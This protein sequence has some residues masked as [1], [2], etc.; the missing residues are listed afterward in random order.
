MTHQP[1]RCKVHSITTPL[2]Q[3]KKETKSQNTTGHT[4]TPCFQAF[5]FFSS[6]TGPPFFFFFF[7]FFLFFCFSFLFFH[8]L[9]SHFPPQLSL[10]HVS[11]HY[12]FGLSWG[13]K[14][15]SKQCQIQRKNDLCMIAFTA[16]QSFF[17]LYSRHGPSNSTS[18]FPIF[19][20]SQQN[21]IFLFFI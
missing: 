3:T 14:A 13:Q 19:N 15:D 21:K 2:K 6:L 4:P 1:M 5:P 10:S 20:G 12:S 9:E 17:L 16:I 7:L 11:I 18:G 8:H